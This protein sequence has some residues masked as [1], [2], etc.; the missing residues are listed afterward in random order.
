VICYINLKFLIKAIYCQGESFNHINHE[1]VDQ[2]NRWLSSGDFDLGS[3]LLLSVMPI[4]SSSIPKISAISRRR[5][6][7]WKADCNHDL[8]YSSFFSF[9]SR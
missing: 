4:N 5:F 9:Y 7:N 1:V 2:I 3:I 8:R 6:V